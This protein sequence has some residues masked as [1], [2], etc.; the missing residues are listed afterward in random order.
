MGDRLQ[1]VEM[2]APTRGSSSS[3]S[4]TSIS[5]AIHTSSVKGVAYHVPWLPTFSIVS[6]RQVQLVVLLVLCSGRRPHMSCSSSRSTPSPV[7]V[8][9]LYL[10]KGDEAAYIPPPSAPNRFTVLAPRHLLLVS[11]DFPAHIMR[12][13][14]SILPNYRSRSEQLLVD[15]VAI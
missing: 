5:C 10:V 9:A 4:R 6:I 11:D 1:L 12:Y 7:H 2:V 14:H 8:H 3:R 13:M 15:V